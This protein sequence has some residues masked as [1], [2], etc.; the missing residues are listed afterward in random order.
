MN[1]CTF[2]EA[3]DSQTPASADQVHSVKAQGQQRLEHLHRGQKEEKDS[4]SEQ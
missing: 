3:H 4:D 2:G 1:Y